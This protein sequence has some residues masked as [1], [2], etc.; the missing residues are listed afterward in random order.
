MQD[1]YAMHSTILVFQPDF[2]QE[3]IT[4]KL[5]QRPLQTSDWVIFII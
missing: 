1:N 4:K 2:S 3:T 5:E